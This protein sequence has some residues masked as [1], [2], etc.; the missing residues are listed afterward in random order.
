MSIEKIEQLVPKLRGHW[1]RFRRHFR[2]KTRDTSEHALAYIQGQMTMETDR[3]FTG[4]ANR[5][6][7]A[8]GQA[9]Q[10]FMSQS[11]W[12]EER[13]YDQIQ[14]EIRETPELQTNG[15]LILD[16]YAN[17]KSGGKNAGTVCQYKRTHG[18]G[19]R[20]SGSRATYSGTR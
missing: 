18:Q 8:D 5:V 3:H 14:S 12:S 15:L 2:T 16:E 1:E 7:S 11:P 17:E 9:L 13:V 6:E 10:H 20:M 4:I 19:G